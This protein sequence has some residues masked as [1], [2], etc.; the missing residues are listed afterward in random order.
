MSNDIQDLIL[1][2]QLDARRC[3]E[4]R[5]APP[6][7]LSVVQRLITALKE[8]SAVQRRVEEMQYTMK[9]TLAHYIL[10]GERQDV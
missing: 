3:M 8:T 6:W 4:E 1:T 10:T 9:P 7:L 5:S 2:A